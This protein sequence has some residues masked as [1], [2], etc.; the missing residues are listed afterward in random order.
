MES[1]AIHV[2][3]GSLR[4]ACFAGICGCLFLF[5]ASAGQ[6]ETLGTPVKTVLL[7][8]TAVGEDQDGDEVI[9]FDCAQPGNRLF[10][11]QVNPKT[12]A[13]RQWMAPVGEGAWAMTIGP[14]NCVYLGTWEDGSLLRFDPKQPEKGI[15]SLGKPSPSQTYIWELVCG[16]DGRLYGCTY[17]SAKLVR[18]DPATGKGE[19]L[20][21]LDPREMYSR[22][23]AASTNGFIY[24]GIGTVRAQVVRFDPATGQTI[25]LIKD[26]Q[27]PPGTAHVFRGGDGQVY[28][29]AHN[30]AYLCD[31]DALRPVRAVVPRRQP[32]L[33][34]GRVVSNTSVAGSAILYE[35]RGHDGEI[36]KKSAKF[37]GAGV[38]VFVVGA[39]PGGRIFGSTVLP[40]EMFD[41]NPVTRELRHLGNPTDVNG[42]IYS[43]AADDRLLYLC[44]YPQSFLSIYDPAKPWRYGRAK[45]SNPRGFGFIGDG[46]L[47]PRAMVIGPDERVYVGSFA[48]YGQTGGALGVYDPKLDAVTE[49]YRHIVT[50]QSIAALSFDPQ[51]KR[52][53]VGSSI[54]AGGGAAATAKECV[55]FAWDTKTRT[56]LWEKTVVKGDTGIGALT[57]A[58][59]RIFGVSLPSNTLFVLNAKTFEVLSTAR[60]PF[61]RFL[62]ISLGYHPSQDR[63]CGLAGQSVFSVNPDTFAM[64]EVARSPDRITC[65][66]AVT[67]TGI[68]FGSGPRLMRWRWN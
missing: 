30:Q 27:R 21:R 8:A 52:L 32:T 23:I 9:Y 17:P 42:E 3:G 2:F 20:G 36:A 5:E 35:L 19:D 33:R 59:G 39:G 25:P 55:V 29:S 57:A 65:G 49:N 68:Y 22:W 66:F 53:F 10:L 44:A 43:F 67:D 51:T 56:K 1:C 46:H 13:V 28:A 60:I 34:D 62:E 12:D 4:S 18:Y 37:D 38:Q 48:P 41:F 64:T 47:R 16:R 45:D 63:I 6:F 11:L 40:L 61:G 14:S 58:H 24:V 15:V 31:G 54:S 7:T 50:N 26:D